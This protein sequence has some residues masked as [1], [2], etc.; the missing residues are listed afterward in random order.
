MKTKLKIIP[1]V[2]LALLGFAANLAG[3]AGTDSAFMGPVQLVFDQYI[4]IQTALA[5]DS[6]K[7]VAANAAAISKEIR[8]DRMKMLAPKVAAQADALAGARDIT[9]AREAFKPLSQS[10]IQY[11]ADKRVSGSKYLEVYCS[12]VKAS[13]LQTDPVINNPYGGKAMSRCGRF[14]AKG[15][16][17][18]SGHAA[19]GHSGH[20]GH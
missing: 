19:H 9:A 1:T 10:L 11:L 6:T 2:V 5:A 7:D 17:I 8:N 3:Q 16:T 15:G 14:V 20:S 4:N 13:W 12:M 18:E